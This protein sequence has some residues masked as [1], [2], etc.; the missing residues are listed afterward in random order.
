MHNTCT[1]V[2]HTVHLQHIY[3]TY[4]NYNSYN[5]YP[6]TAPTKACNTYETVTQHNTHYIN[7]YK[8]NTHQHTHS[9]T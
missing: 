3:N 9:S 2:L 4:N 1:C 6:G 7:T 5:I 8:T